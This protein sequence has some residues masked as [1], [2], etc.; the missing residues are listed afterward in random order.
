MIFSMPFRKLGI[1]DIKILK[2]TIN[3]L[4]MLE[5]KYQ[6]G[7]GIGRRWHHSKLTGC[8]LANVASWYFPIINEHPV[9]SSFVQVY[10]YPTIYQSECIFPFM[11]HFP[12]DW[13]LIATISNN[14]RQYRIMYFDRYGPTYSLHCNRQSTSGLGFYLSSGLPEL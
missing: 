3:S 13:F 2:K 10:V 1:K 11:E 6:N 7:L 8:F 9:V 12:T 4:D 5:T 14:N